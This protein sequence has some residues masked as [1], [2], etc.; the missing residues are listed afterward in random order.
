MQWAR[1]Y[2]KKETA[3][4]RI[5]KR[6]DDRGSEMKPKRTRK[7]K[8]MREAVDISPEKYFVLCNGTTIKDIH[9][10]A[11]VIESI[12]DDEFRFHVNA[13][14]NDFSNWIR[15]V[16]AQEA[17]AEKLKGTECRKEFQIALLKHVI[18]DRGVKG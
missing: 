17:L 12:S 3:A 14:K 6:L 13:E 8:K 2:R 11:H 4:S 15:D 16:F 1:H 10:L 9:E 18:A 5:M 7:T